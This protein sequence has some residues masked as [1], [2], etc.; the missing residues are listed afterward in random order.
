M[1]Y[2][3]ECWFEPITARFQDGFASNPTDLSKVVE[4]HEFKRI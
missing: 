4:G 2:Y 1:E 3:Y